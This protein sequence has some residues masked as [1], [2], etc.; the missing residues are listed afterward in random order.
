M[1]SWMGTIERAANG[2]QRRPQFGRGGLRLTCLPASPWRARARRR[3]TRGKVGLAGG[4]RENGGLI[5]IPDIRLSLGF[6]VMWLLW[7]LPTISVGAGDH[8]VDAGD[9]VVE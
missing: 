1:G 7:P 8:G 4:G 3:P 9:H 2:P 6:S 5:A